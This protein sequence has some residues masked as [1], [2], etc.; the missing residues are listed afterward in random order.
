V[1]SED[2]T[3]IQKDRQ[4]DGHSSFH[5]FSACVRNNLHLK[6]DFAVVDGLNKD[7]F[8]FYDA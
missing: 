5:R 1:K 4:M 6:C 7:T 2:F 3:R 8:M